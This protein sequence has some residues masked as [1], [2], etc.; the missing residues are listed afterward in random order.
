MSGLAVLIVLLALVCYNPI[1][2]QLA[3]V[4]LQIESYGV[5]QFEQGH[6]PYRHIDTIL[7]ILSLIN[8][9]ECLCLYCSGKVPDWLSR[10]GVRV[11]LE[12]RLI[13]QALI[14]AEGSEV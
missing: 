12:Q 2:E 4:L 7:F 10:F 1:V 13:K 6:I 5:Q 9:Y 11:V 14:G 8:L 3:P